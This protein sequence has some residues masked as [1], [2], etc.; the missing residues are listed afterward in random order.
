MLE[1][2]TYKKDNGDIVQVFKNEC[3]IRE[4]ATLEKMSTFMQLTNNGAKSDAVA[5]YT[6]IKSMTN[7]YTP[8]KTVAQLKALTN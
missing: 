1:S 5:F 2:L 3:T 4:F 7:Q 8:I 6:C